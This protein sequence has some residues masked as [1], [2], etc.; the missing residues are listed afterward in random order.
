MIRPKCYLPVRGKVFYTPLIKENLRLDFFS[1]EYK[2]NDLPLLI[3]SM[4]RDGKTTDDIVAVTLLPRD[5]IENVFDELKSHGMLDEHDEYNLPEHT[6]KILELSDAINAF[7]LD[8]P[9][10]FSDMLTKLPIMLPQAVK[11]QKSFDE[12]ICAAVVKNCE[13]IQTADFEDVSKFVKGFLVKRGAG[14]LIDDLKVLRLNYS[15]ETFLAARE[16]RYLPVMGENDFNGVKID[17]ERTINAELP[18]HRFTA[19]TSM[20][21]RSY[22]FDLLFGTIFEAV[23]KE[24]DDSEE[25]TLSFKANPQFQ[26][27]MLRQRVSAQFGEVVDKGEG[28]ANILVAEDVAGDFL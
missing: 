22:N 11:P 1:L 27:D 18:V 26:G 6:R 13:Q 12:S 15:A 23:E 10:I 25:I 17:S 5:I 3:A 14:N 4:L 21:E 28:Y 7:N 9:P 24:E 2:L 19:E 16:L 20:G 8:A